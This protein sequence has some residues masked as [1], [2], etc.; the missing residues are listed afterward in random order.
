MFFPIFEL[1]H[2][3]GNLHDKRWANLPWAMVQTYHCTTW[4]PE[5]M[6]WSLNFTHNSPHF[7]YLI[8]P[9]YSHS[10]VHSIDALMLDW[11]SVHER[12]GILM[13][14]L[15]KTRRISFAETCI[16]KWKIPRSNSRNDTRLLFYWTAY[17]T[18]K[19]SSEGFHTNWYSVTM[20][21][22]FMTLYGH[23]WRI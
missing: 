4:A 18:G 10:W 19:H 3:D 12:Y 20:K 21:R 13:M 17:A 22:W 16:I 7:N 15:E 14:I 11:F 2:L 1:V 5:Y 6:I 8:D 23:S 9:Y